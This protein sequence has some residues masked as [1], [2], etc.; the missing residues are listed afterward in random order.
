MPIDRG[1]VQR[2]IAALKVMT[3]GELK[4]RYE[5]LFGEVS[6]SSNRRYLIR[7]CAWRIQALAEGDLSQ[8]AR[9]RAL[10]LARDV[11]IRI[12]APRDFDLGGDAPAISCPAAADPDDPPTH[13]TLDTTRRLRLTRD[14]R[15]PMP[16][17]RLTRVYKGHEYTVEVMSNGLWYEGKLYRSLSAV[18]HAITGS[19]WNGY[20]FFKIAEGK[21]ADAQSPDTQPAAPGHATKESR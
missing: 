18:A 4:R 10:A 17:T 5:D 7:K 9:R 19:H 12:Q 6:R 21:P 14:D 3:V 1:G 16:G 20:L 8:R 2:D 11:D 15:L 13:R